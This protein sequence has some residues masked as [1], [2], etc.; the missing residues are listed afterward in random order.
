MRWR[1]ALANRLVGNAESAAGLEIAVTG[2]A[3]RFAC[4]TTIALTGADFGARSMASA[5]PTLARG[6]GDG[7]VAA[8]NGDGAGRGRRAYLAV[9]GGIDVPEYLGSRSTFILGGFGGHAGRVLRAGDVL[10]SGRRARQRRADLAE[11][12]SAHTRTSG[13]SA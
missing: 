1:S 8:R 7:G 6:A 5:V 11:R 9:A 10:A 3:L 2:P 13:R 4:D 12:R